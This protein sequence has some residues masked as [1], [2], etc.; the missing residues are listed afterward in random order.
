MLGVQ[1]GSIDVAGSGDAAP[2]HGETNA[3]TDGECSRRPI[4]KDGG[5][6]PVAF[7]IVVLVRQHRQRGTS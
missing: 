7:R 4:E 6:A 2:S 5:V 1:L 3:A